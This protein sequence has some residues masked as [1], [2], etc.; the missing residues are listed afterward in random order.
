[1]VSELSY[2]EIF[3]NYNINGSQD[4]TLGADVPSKFNSSTGQNMVTSRSTIDGKHLFFQISIEINE[5]LA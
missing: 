2:V 3:H 5:D 1:M 4:S